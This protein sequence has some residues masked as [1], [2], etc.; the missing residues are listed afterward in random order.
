[1]WLNDPNCAPRGLNDARRRQWLTAAGLG[2]AGLST[3]A[4]AR[5]SRGVTAGASA[6][7]AADGVWSDCGVPAPCV[8]L[9]AR[10]LGTAEPLVARNAEQSFALA[11]TAKLVTSMAALDLLGPQFRWRT[12]AFLDGELQGGRLHGDLWI[13]GGGDVRLSSADLA[14]WMA[15]WR[16]MG[17]REISG[18]IV[19]DRFAFHLG[20]DDFAGTPEP[21]V[22]R[23]HHARPDALTVD[24]GVLRVHLSADRNGKPRVSVSPPLAGLSIETQFNANGGCEPSAAWDIASP[25]SGRARLILQGDWHPSCGATEIR[26]ALPHAEYTTRAIAGL[27]TQAGGR[28]RG[29]IVNQGLSQ[30]ATLFPQGAAGQALQ[31]FSTHLSPAL[32][33]LLRDM[34]KT[35]DNLA[36]RHLMLALAAGF[37]ARA[38]TLP[39]AQ[40]RMRDWLKAQGLGP[41]D[42]SI[43]N[44]SGLSRGERAKPRAMVQL[45]ERAWQHRQAG[46][47]VD[48]LPLAGVDGTLRGR[49]RSGAATGHAYLKTGTLMDTRALAGYV[50]TRQGHLVAVA[51]LVNHP[52]ATRAV[53][54]LDRFI[55][56]LAR[57]D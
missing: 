25:A 8:G 31:P 29:R 22:D 32:P 23:P 50:H 2:L 43:E 12:F 41:D 33:D 14:R 19:L 6:Q 52:E 1:M 39:G 15:E 3:P 36:A 46:T 35:S 4:L 48:S 5:V 49:L 51:A 24:E 28:L 37:P 57:Y 30:R 38:A 7:A 40:R 18:N 42:L 13:V 56:W 47:L 34:N 26:A 53:P 27:W 44:G 21:A 55:E 45:L 20:A 16:A 17:L 10:V 11:S 54:A 9:Y